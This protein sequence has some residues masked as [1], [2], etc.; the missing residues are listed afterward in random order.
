MKKGILLALSL[1]LVVSLTA[2]CSSSAVSP[3]SSASAVSGAGSAASDTAKTNFPNGKPIT[4]IVPWAAGGG[5]DV[6]A[7]I[8]QPYLQDAL[9][10]TITV[11]NPTGASGWV[12]WEQM[13]NGKADGYTVAMVNFPTLFAGYL[14]TSLGRSLTIDDF[15]LLANHVTDAS[16]LVVR[17]DDTRFSDLKSFVEYAKSHEVTASTSGPGSDDDM[18]L[19]TLK[20]KY[21]LKLTQ[22][23]GDGWKDGEAALLGKHID[24][25]IANV[26]EVMD[27]CNKGEAKCIVVFDKERSK[28]ISDSPTW[29]EVMGDELLVS[30]QR[31]FACKA[32]TPKEIVDILNAAFQ[33]AINNPEQ[34]AKMDKLGLKVDY[35]DSTSYTEQMKEEETTMLG[36][37]DLFGWKK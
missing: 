4:M 19:E 26:G 34:V 21:G 8:L 31:G 20:S 11:T 13:L 27:P 5:S 36:M 35:I 28:F 22:V 7:R 14:D 37:S 30:S 18:V 33:S 10:T 25:S 15:T 12:G 24:C 29:K 16:V 6:G 17:K 1:S 2:G 3:A 9:H 23:A 32:G